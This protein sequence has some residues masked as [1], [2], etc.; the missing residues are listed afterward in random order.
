VS[1][2]PLLVAAA[3]GA[4]LS[5][6]IV[7]L[8]RDAAVRRDLLDVPNARSSHARPTPRLGGLGIVAAVALSMAVAQMLFALDARAAVILVGLGLA[9]ALV[10]LVDDLRGLP[11]LARLTVHLAAGAAAVAA[12]GPLEVIGD[13]G[14]ADPGLARRLDSVLT[15]LW[16]AGFMNAFNFMDGIDGIAGGQGLVAGAATAAIGWLH[17]VPAATVLGATMAAACLGFLLHNWSPATIFMGD[18]GSA[19][20]GFLIATA[21]MVAPATA[22][23]PVGLL[24]FALVVWPF[25]FDTML[26]FVRRAV[27]GENVMAAHKTHFYQRLTQAGWSHGR[28]AAL[29][30]ALAGVA[31]ALVVSPPALGRPTIPAVGFVAVAASALWLLVVQAERHLQVRPAGATGSVEGSPRA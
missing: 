10:S 2:A 30:T 15:V 17:G 16:I 1:L 21:P 24:P 6:L 28:V 7:A 11:A 9:V 23:P 20:L 22:Q 25:L 31:A 27:R 29:Y 19:F 26:T 8:V 4:G 13:L 5:W 18:V 3:L 14:V 12:L